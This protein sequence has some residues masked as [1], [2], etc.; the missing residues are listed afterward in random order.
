MLNAS[1]AGTFLGQALQDLVSSSRKTPTAEESLQAAIAWLERA[2]N[3]S[4]DKG[5]SHGFSLKKGG[6]RRGYVETTGYIICTMFDLERRFPSRGHSQ[7]AIDMGR[8]LTEQQLPDGSF[9]N[10]DLNPSKG[11][12]FDTGQDLLG[13]V[14]LYKETEDKVFLEAGGRAAT[15]LAKVSDTDGLWSNNTYKD[16]PHVYNTRSAWAL[17]QYY[18]LD[19]QPELLR[20]AQANLDWALHQQNEAG[21]WNNCAFE[22]GIAP[23]THTIAY[24]AR[25]LLESGI[26]LGDERYIT[27]SRRAA[28]TVMKFLHKDG[29]L[30]GQIAL[31]GTSTPW[32]CCLTGNCQMAIVWQRLHQQHPSEEMASAAARALHYVMKRQQ[33]NQKKHDTFGAIAG[34][35]PIWGLYH[36][37]QYPNWATKFLVDALLM[38]DPERL[39]D[40]AVSKITQ[41]REIARK[42]TILGIEFDTLDLDETVQ[43]C[44]DLVKRGERAYPYN[45]N[46]NIIAKMATHP[47]VGRWVRGARFR[48]AD[49]LPLVWLSKWWTDKPLPERVTGVSLMERLIEGAAKNDLSI[50]LLGGT[51]DV[52]ERLIQTLQNKYPRLNIAGHADGFFDSEEEPSRVEAIAKSNAQILMVC[53][54]VPRQ[55]SF[56]DH[57]WDNLN[58]NLALV[59]GGAFDVLCGLKQ[60]APLFYQRTGLEWI[61]RLF[62]APKQ[63]FWRYIDIYPKFVGMILSDAIRRLSG[64]DA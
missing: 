11:L 45:L 28:H 60:R 26:L 12:V 41:S 52:N 21:W 34:S 50:Y 61:Y 51:A 54:G 8:W 9:P 56:V 39:T 14:R 10:V 24:T 44:I 47:A 40:S 33:I 31:D 46:A 13:L 37:L 58:V 30:P 22:A 55:E 16:V 18:Q 15:W 63:Y 38:I 1:V 42:T 53:M 27:S 2:H 25:G 49:G 23:F 43:A 59:G 62:Q 32:Y 17:L 57:N 20:V 4:P 3:Q 5:V 36:P 64:R 29:F 19:P 6:W 48:V 7:R 35:Y